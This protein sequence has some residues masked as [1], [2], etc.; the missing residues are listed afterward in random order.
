MITKIHLC[1]VLKMNHNV[2][3]YELREP[4]HICIELQL[5]LIFGQGQP[6]LLK[7]KLHM[8]AQALTAI[9]YTR[10]CEQLFL[11]FP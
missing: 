8:F 5:L 6:Y 11:S 1:A 4:G 3:V 10:C 7:T 9:D 2:C